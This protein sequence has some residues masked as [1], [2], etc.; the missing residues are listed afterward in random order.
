[1]TT[2]IKQLKDM[3]SRSRQQL[4]S[5]L[6]RIGDRSEEQ[7]Y[8][9]GAGWTLRQL[10]IHLLITERGIARVV[11]SIYN[12]HNPITPDYDV[13]RYNQRSVE[14]HADTTLSEVIAG[15]EAAR[16]EF[17]QWLDTVDEAKLDIVALHPLQDTIPLWQFIERQAHHEQAHAE[18]IEQH[19]KKAP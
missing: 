6:E 8:S 7:I 18:D 17:L 11:Q 4:L 10:A 19:L 5:A 15:L 3:L 13:D 16:A 12:G 9:E 2:R 1:M 14:K